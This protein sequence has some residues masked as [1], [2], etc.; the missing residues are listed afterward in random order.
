[1]AAHR[2]IAI[3]TLRVVLSSVTLGLVE[4]F[5]DQIRKFTLHEIG[6][7]VPQDTCWLRLHNADVMHAT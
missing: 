6:V 5:K 2:L 7:D 4:A 3:V 1:L